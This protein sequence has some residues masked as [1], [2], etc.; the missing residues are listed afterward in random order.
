MNQNEES[1][2]S[3]LWSTIQKKSSNE[4]RKIIKDYNYNNQ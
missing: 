2:T 1:E 3:L 4:L